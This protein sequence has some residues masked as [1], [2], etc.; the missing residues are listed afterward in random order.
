MK[1]LYVFRIKIFSFY[2]VLIS[3]LTA[4]SQ[5]GNFYGKVKYNSNEPAVAIFIALKGDQVEKETNSNV[6]GSFNFKDIPYGDYTITFY[7]LNDLPKIVSVKLDSKNKEVNVILEISALDEVFVKSKTV[8]QKIEEKGFAVNVIETKEA[9]IQSIQ[10]NE[11]LDQS[12]GVRVRQSG[13]LGSHAHYNLNGMTGNSVKIFID[14]VPIRNFGPSF[15]LN[16]IPPSLIKRIEVYKGVVPPHLSDDAMGG[17]I[18]VVLNDITKNEL[19]ASISTGSFGTYR[20]DVNGG[21][22]NNKNGFT[23]RGSAFVNYA[24]NDYEVWGNQVAVALSAGTPDVYIHAK[25]FHDRYRSQGGKAE[26]GF[27]NVEW[28]DK[29]LAGVL[30]SNMDQQIQTGA[31]MEIVYGNRHTEQS[32][33]MYSLDFAKENI[34]KNLDVSAFVSYSR[35]NRKTIDTIATQY[36]W[37][38]YPTSYFNDPD[39]WSSGA[40]AGDPTLQKDI[41]ETVNTRT[42]LA[43]HINENNTIQLNHLLNTFTRDSDDP[44]LPAAENA[45]KEE[46]KYL[47]SILTVSLENKAFDEKLRTSV[48]GKS[49]YMDRTSKLRT[50]SSNTSGSTIIIDENNITSNDFGFGGSISYSITPKITVFGS[51]EKAIRL[52]ESDEVFGNVASNLNASVNLKPEHSNNYNLGFTYDNIQLKKHTFGI[53]SNIFIRDTE[54]LIMSFPTGSNEE[55]FENSNIGK[56]YTE[57]FDFTLNYNYNEALF[58]SANTSFFNARDYNVTYDVNGN[59]ITP[60]YERLANTPY[61]T[62]NYNLKFNTKNFIQKGSTLSTYTNVLYVHEFF[63]GSSVLGGSGK[64]VIPGQVSFDAGFAYTFPKNKVSLSFDVKNILNKQLFDN[65]ALQKPGRGFYGKLTFSIL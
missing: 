38:G 47:K 12:A 53:T 19:K 7:S 22:R 45:L 60:S 52:P 21:Y 41:D 5:N 62:M 3:S 24:D 51:A 25:R 42:N 16:S 44:M 18:N 1:N 49:Y 23:A 4:F 17:A 33:N 48:F 8:Q 43:Y 57:G 29:L 34:A 54:D 63:R 40:E 14:G 46:R 9:A 59:P 64:I 65:Y 56:I 35:L 58:F 11:M 30:L 61:F 32:T 36:S 31:T 28:A 55:F 37:L 13:G 2:L 27:T 15:S 20:T 26:F 39:V 10:V 50:R 6:N